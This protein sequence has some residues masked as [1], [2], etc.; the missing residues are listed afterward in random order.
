[1]TGF[2][3]DFPRARSANVAF[4]AFFRKPVNLERLCETL[5]ALRRGAPV[6][7]SERY[8]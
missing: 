6:S 4:K 1:M 2:Y 3:E 5:A 8:D 7:E